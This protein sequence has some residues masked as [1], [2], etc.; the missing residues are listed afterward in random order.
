MQIGMGDGTICFVDVTIM[1]QQVVS[2]CPPSYIYIYIY[3]C[4]CVLSC[5]L[6]FPCLQSYYCYLR[7][8]ILTPR[9]HE[10][11]PPIMRQLQSSNMIETPILLTFLWQVRWSPASPS[12]CCVPIRQASPSFIT[13]LCAR[14]IHITDAHT[15]ITD[16]HTYIYNRS[17]NIHITEARIYM[18]V[19][20]D[21]RVAGVSALFSFISLQVCKFL[22][23]IFL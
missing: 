16:A 7:K 8:F 6:Y 20:G 10:L 5:F 1:D 11:S 14:Y 4:L 9:S 3:V 17:T 21:M 18:C 12:P 15:Y 13:L 23:L 2:S 19:L 22:L